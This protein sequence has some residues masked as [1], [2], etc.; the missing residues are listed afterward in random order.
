MAQNV[1]IYLRVLCKNRVGRR[2]EEENAG[3]GEREHMRAG[4]MPG[5]LVKNSLGKKVRRVGGDR[6]DLTPSAPP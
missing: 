6:E 1:C 2:F 4:P 3:G 5:F